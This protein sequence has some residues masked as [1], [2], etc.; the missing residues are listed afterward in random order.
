MS[1]AV[2]L[3]GGVGTRLWPRSRQAHPKQFSDITGSS[4]TMIQET[5]DRLNG[6]IPTENIYIVTGKRYAELAT[7]QLPDLPAANII[8][9]PYGRDTGPAIG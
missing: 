3:A 2:I 9:E 8:V 4:R 7:S 6:V 1:Y 5:V